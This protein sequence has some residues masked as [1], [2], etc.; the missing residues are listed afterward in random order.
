M[1]NV[2]RAHQEAPPKLRIAIEKYVS[3]CLTDG[4]VAAKRPRVSAGLIEKGI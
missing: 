1:T 3:A 4:D 2:A